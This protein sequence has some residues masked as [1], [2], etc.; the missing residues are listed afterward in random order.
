MSKQ[1]NYVFDDELYHHGILGQR[2]GHR[3]FQNED[4]SW[5]PEGRERYSEGDKSRQAVKPKI[6]SR[7]KIRSSFEEKKYKL[8]MKSKEQKLKDKIAAN[9][10][11]NRVREQAKTTR[12]ANKEQAKI[13][14]KEAIRNGIELGKTKS[15]SNDDLQTAINR[16]KLE[17]EY[18]K[19]YAIAS[20]PNSALARADRF[21][22]GPTGQ[23]VKAVAV[24]TLPK[25][26]EQATSKILESKLKYVNKLDRE[27]QQ[28]DI[29]K[30]IA[31]TNKVDAETRDK[32]QSTINATRESQNKIRLENEKADQDK[33]SADREFEQQQIRDKNE[34]NLNKFDRLHNAAVEK[35][36]LKLKQQKQEAEQSRLNEKQKHDIEMDTKSK[37]G[38]RDQQNWFHKGTIQLDS[39]ERSR[40]LDKEKW[41]IDRVNAIDDDMRDMVKEGKL[42][43]ET[44]AKTVTST[45]NFLR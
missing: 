41:A 28:A 9:E 15:M 32:I 3:R 26:A 11:R 6:D 37:L 14:R 20:K 30:Q 8:Y 10:E 35:A 24:A 38:F 5:T 36:D 22:E 12:L 16:L 1:P 7:A 40:K 25:M 13:D 19:S 42:S 29:A 2:W 45:P 4:G 33:I 23:V 17:A 34:Y 18:N 39:E 31:D 43:P 27:K 44:F 21:F